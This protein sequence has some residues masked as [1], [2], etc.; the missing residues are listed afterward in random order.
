MLKMVIFLYKTFETVTKGI[1]MCCL[2]I[3]MF[4]KVEGWCQEHWIM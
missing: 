3:F 4:C 1:D 2:P